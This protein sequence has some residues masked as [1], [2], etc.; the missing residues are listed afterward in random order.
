MLGTAALVIGTWEGM[1]P[2]RLPPPYSLAYLLFWL[3]YGWCAW[4]WIVSAL[5][6]ARRHLDRAGSLTKR[7]ESQAYAWYI[8]HQPIIIVIAFVVVQWS[9]PLPVKVAVLFLASCAGTVA[10]TLMLRRLRAIAGRA[11][12]YRT[13]DRRASAARAATF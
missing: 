4:A 6:F 3:L 8:L 11:G 1:V 10:A 12:Q 9:A 7:A 13:P 5:G 2:A